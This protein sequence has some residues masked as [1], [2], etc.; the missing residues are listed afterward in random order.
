MGQQAVS[1]CRN[2]HLEQEAENLHAAWR[3]WPQVVQNQDRH[4][5]IYQ[6]RD[7]L[8]TLEIVVAGCCLLFDVVWDHDEIAAE[9]VRRWVWRDKTRRY[10]SVASVEWDK[11]MVFWN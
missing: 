8:E 6:G 11:R 7:S 2:G 9:T 5:L 1:A 10:S 3:T 4:T